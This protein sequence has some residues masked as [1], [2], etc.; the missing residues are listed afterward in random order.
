MNYNKIYTNLIEK[1]KARRSF[2]FSYYESH[3]ILPRCMGGGNEK[4]NLVK[5]SAKEHFVAHHLLMKIYPSNKKLAKAFTMMFRNRDCILFTQ[6]QYAA[7]KSA[8]SFSSSMQKKGYVRVKDLEGNSISVTT[9]EYRSRKDV[10]LVHHNT[11]KIHDEDYRNK[12]SELLSGRIPWNAGQKIGST[13]SHGYAYGQHRIGKQH[14][15]DTK[16]KQ[17][18]GLVSFYESNPH[19]TKGKKQDRKICPHCGKEGGNL[20]LRWHFD[21]CKEKQK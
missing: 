6:S 10:D 11:G 12:M 2:D 14:S 8:Y 21:N 13:Q 4:S 15:E 7:R 9:E 20:M 5:L 1:A 16:R 18:E 19:H 17:S 3:H